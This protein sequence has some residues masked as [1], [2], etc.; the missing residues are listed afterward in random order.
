[1][2]PAVKPLQTK[3]NSRKRT[4]MSRLDDYGLIS[5][6]ARNCDRCLALVIKIRRGELKGVV[7]SCHPLDEIVDSDLRKYIESREISR[8]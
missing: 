8:N 7:M 3:K 4:L 2:L 5:K 6:E 1:V